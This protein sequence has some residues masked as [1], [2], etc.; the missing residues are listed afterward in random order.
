M[1]KK[2]VMDAMVMYAVKGQDGPVRSILWL[3]IRSKIGVILG[4][5]FVT[6]HM[7]K[8]AIRAIVH[9]FK[10]KAV[11]EDLLKNDNLMMPIAT[12]V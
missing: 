3:A 5:G 4:E 8:T 10:I 11:F 7:Q 12:L 2:T 9:P 1:A 6:G